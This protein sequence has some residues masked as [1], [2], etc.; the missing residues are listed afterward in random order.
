MLGF[1][2][3]GSGRA[4]EYRGGWGHRG[5]PAT[6]GGTPGQ[7]SGRNA[8][9]VSGRRWAVGRDGGVGH[10]RSGRR[11][12]VGGGRG[13]KHIAAMVAPLWL[14]KE[15]AGRRRKEEG[16]MHSPYRVT[17]RTIGGPLLNHL[18]GDALL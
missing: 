9:A 12:Q 7:C 13:G 10:Q 3:W 18:V 5:G 16:V 1:R 6:G 4:P 2:L 14:W 11:S 15:E 8:T 17:G